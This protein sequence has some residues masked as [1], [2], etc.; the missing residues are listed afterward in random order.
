[1]ATNKSG[2]PACGDNAIMAAG[3]SQLLDANR[4][5]KAGTV[6]AFRMV[7]PRELSCTLAEFSL[8]AKNGWG[9]TWFD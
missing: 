8:G 4:R 2:T 5:A 1:M 7:A 3:V 9:W 6:N